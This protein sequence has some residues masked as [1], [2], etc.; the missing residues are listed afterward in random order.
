[1][2]WLSSVARERSLR[3]GRRLLG[4]PRTDPN[5]KF[6]PIRFFGRTRFRAPRHFPSDE[7]LITDFRDPRSC[8]SYPCQDPFQCF[9]GEVLAFSASPVEPFKSAGYGPTVE[10]VQRLDVADKTAVVV[11]TSQSGIESSES[12]SSVPS[13]GVSAPENVC[14]FGGPRFTPNSRST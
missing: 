11:V 2:P 3:Q 1:M 5:V 4:A 14:D 12:N 13:L 6:S 10:S 8:N 9:R 7:R